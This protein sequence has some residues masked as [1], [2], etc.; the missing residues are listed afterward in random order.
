MSTP[1]ADTLS[2]AAAAAW[3]AYQAMSASKD[4]YFSMLRAM[5]EKYKT[6]GAPAFAEGLRMEQLLAEHDRKVKLFN[7][8]L[9]ALTDP[10]AR[11]Q[12]MERLKAAADTG[13]KH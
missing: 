8:A 3:R 10:A 9:T 6:G 12:L 13:G 7:Q 1:P 4:E 11:Q 5:D 2:P